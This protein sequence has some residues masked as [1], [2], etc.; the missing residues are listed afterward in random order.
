MTSTK[1]PIV[2]VI[3]HAGDV[4]T[5]LLNA[6]KRMNLKPHA[7]VR[8]LTMKI[9]DDDVAPVNLNELGTK[10]LDAASK[11]KSGDGVA[12]IADVAASNDVQEHYK[13]WLSMGVSVCTANKGIFAVM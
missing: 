3:V 13:Q 4:G 10:L 7:I 2:A 9:N 8:S 11:Q 5:C 12:I 6:M 1:V